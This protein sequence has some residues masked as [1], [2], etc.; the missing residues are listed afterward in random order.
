MSRTSI[1]AICAAG[2]GLACLSSA[3]AQEPG[4]TP[5]TIRIGTFGALTGPG[6]LYGKLPMNGV[7]V[8]FDEINKAGG[9]HGRK[10]ELVREDDRCDP[11]AAIG[12]T[13]KLIAQDK[14]F[15]I[16]GGGCSNPTLAARETI[17]KAG[18]PFV[19][20]ASVHDGITTPPAKNIFSVATTSTIES[21]AQ[22]QFALNE[23]AKKIA[24]VS[25]RD[26]WGRARYNPLM[27]TLKA[28]GVKIVADEE[29]SPDANDA[30]AQVLRLK[31]AGADAILMILYPKPAAVF[32][33]KASRAAW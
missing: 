21:Q 9:I 23:G 22:V 3:S 19:V 11:A 2:L 15:A 7:E 28:K 20:F 6:Y 24:V 8:V 27:E 16:V 18:T 5:T 4:L 29:M 25:M 12:A 1:S 30:T 17:E 32:A 10:L 33:R 31:Q 13:Q 14:V 26:S